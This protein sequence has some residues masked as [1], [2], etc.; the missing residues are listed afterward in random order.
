MLS[1]RVL[2]VGHVPG[3]DMSGTESLPLAYPMGKGSE[4][5]KLFEGRWIHQAEQETELVAAG[6]TRTAHLFS[7]EDTC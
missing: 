1:Y 4:C 7:R 2:M 6:G 3:E 5:H